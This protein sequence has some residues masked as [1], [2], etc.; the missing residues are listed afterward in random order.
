VRRREGR[1]RPLLGQRGAPLGGVAVPLG[2]AKSD[3]IGATQDELCVSTAGKV[4]CFGPSMNKTLTLVPGF[5]DATLLAGGDGLMCALRKS[6][7][8]TCGDWWAAA[9]GKVTDKATDARTVAVGGSFECIVGKDDHIACN[10]ALP[11][12]S[13]IEQL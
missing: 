1:P 8:V 13:V 5:A 4:S 3:G 6:G 10:A 2:V 7:V 9:D 12:K 11:T